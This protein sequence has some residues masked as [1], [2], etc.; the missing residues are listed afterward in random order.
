MI[1]YFVCPRCRNDNLESLTPSGYTWY[2]NCLKC[3]II[4]PDIA[5][6]H[7]EPITANDG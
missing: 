5:V 1:Y 6:K 2:A 3:G 7:P 4:I